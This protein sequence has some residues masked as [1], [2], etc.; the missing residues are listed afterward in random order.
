MVSH[1]NIMRY[2]RI[3]A[4]SIVPKLLVTLLCLF[5]CTWH[6]GFYE[7]CPLENHFIYSFF[8]ANGFHLAINLMVLWQIRGKLYPLT[9]ILIAVASSF[10]PMYVDQPTMGLS[11]FLFAEFGILWGQTG[12]WKDAI[13][14]AMP[15][16]LFTML[17]LNTNGLLHLYTFV[18]G[19]SIGFLHKLFHKL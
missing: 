1:T 19:Y 4:R 5:N 9:A 12:R 7:G 14:K 2:M 10:L 6:V 17:L 13:K 8:H 11:G 18:I 3:N 15:F 16:I